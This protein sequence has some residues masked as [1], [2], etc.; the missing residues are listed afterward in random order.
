M[1]AK[2]IKVLDDKKGWIEIGELSKNELCRGVAD[3]MKQAQQMKLQ[4]DSIS[5]IY[6]NHLAS[7]DACD[8]LY[9]DEASDKAKESLKRAT[10]L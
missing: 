4:I 6:G 1:N 10:K 7:L 2:K 3:M 5:T 9:L 8:V